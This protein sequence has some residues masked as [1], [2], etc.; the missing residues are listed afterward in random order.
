[1][2]GK[3]KTPATDRLCQLAGTQVPLPGATLRKL[4]GN[5]DEYAGRVTRRITELTSDG[6]FLP[7]YADLVRDDLKGINI[8]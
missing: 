7:E 1:M 4:C 2:F 8:P 5:K 6:W 3:G